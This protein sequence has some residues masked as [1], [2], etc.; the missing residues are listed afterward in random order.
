VKTTWAKSDDM[1]VCRS[2]LE[3]GVMVTDELCARLPHHASGSIRMRLQNFDYLATGGASGLPNVAA[4]TREV[5][6]LVRNAAEQARV[7]GLNSL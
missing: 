4:Q 3:T 1:I 6:A 2:Y 5:W 7:G